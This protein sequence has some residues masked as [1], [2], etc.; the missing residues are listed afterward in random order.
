MESNLELNLKLTTTS[1]VGGL[2]G[3]WV[4]VILEVGVELLNS[5]QVNVHSMYI[6]STTSPGGWVG[7]RSDRTKVILNS[8]QVEFEVRVVLS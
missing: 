1:P 5:T 8:T 6:F 2:G 3:G 7:G 4:E